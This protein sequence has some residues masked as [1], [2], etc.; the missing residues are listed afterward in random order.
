MAQRRISDPIK[1][2]KRSVC[3]WWVDDRATYGRYLEVEPRNVI[4]TY[5]DL[6][7]AV[8]L[9][10]AELREYPIQEILLE[11][12][13]KNQVQLAPSSLKVKA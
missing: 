8:L 2:C 10:D 4:A 6:G 1:G 3:A 7:N 13:A 9:S 5:S 11:T 12:V